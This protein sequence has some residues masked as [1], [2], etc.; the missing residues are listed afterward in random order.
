MTTM[1]DNN[2]PKPFFILE[3]VNGTR[4]YADGKW[5]SFKEAFQFKLELERMYPK[6]R[7]RV[8]KCYPCYPQKRTADP[9]GED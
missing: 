7:Y 1:E 6:R 2:R 3:K 8:L 4:G 5:D 9:T